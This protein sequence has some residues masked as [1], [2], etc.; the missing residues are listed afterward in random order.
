MKKRQIFFRIRLLKELLI[1]TQKARHQL[2]DELVVN[3][4]DPVV[5]MRRYRMLAQ[6]SILEAQLIEK[7]Y[8]IDTDCEDDLKKSIYVRRCIRYVTDRNG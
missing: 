7:V 4:T 8:K 1:E 3:A 2:L 6:L 5:S